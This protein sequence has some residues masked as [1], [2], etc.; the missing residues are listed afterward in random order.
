[1]GTLLANSGMSAALAAAASRLGSAY[2]AVAPWVGGLGGF[3]TGSNTGASAMFAASQAQTAQAIGYPMLTMVALQ[4]V[5]ASLT[6]MAA[7]PKVVLA[8][9]V[10]QDTA[11][12][13]PHTASDS[14]VRATYPVTSKATVTAA[15]SV[16]PRLETGRI[17]RTV[18]AVDVVI[19]AVLSGVA[20]LWPS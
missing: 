14:A 7:I 20:L 11:P 1:M 12:P 3:V 19:L 17:L 9:S 2:P 6:T 18:L 15:T 5:S 16:A 4:N 8:S 10:A 13:A